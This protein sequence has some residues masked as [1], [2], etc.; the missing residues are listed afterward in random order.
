MSNHVLTLCN[1]GSP[2]RKK[3]LY[4]HQKHVYVKIH[5]YRRK[6][7]NKL[8]LIIKIILIL[9]SP[10]RLIFGK[11]INR[12]LLALLFYKPYSILNAIYF[13]VSNYLIRV[14]KIY[15]IRTLTFILTWY[16]NLHFLNSINLFNIVQC[17]QWCIKFII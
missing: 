5:P 7:V 11:N 9:T 6:V 1:L 15:E 12:L 2:V 14:I 4:P 10:W 3:M 16:L 17:L 13:D 8:S